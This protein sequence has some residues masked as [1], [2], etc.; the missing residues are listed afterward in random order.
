MVI[1][2]IKPSIPMLREIQILSSFTDPELTQLSALGTTRVYEPHSSI[3]IEGESSWGV[4]LI[5]RGL[6]NISKTNKLS[7]NSYDLGRL[8]EGSFFGEMSLVDENP[9]SATVRALSESHLFYISKD[10]FNQLLA[11]A[12]GLK[13]RFFESCVKQ[14][15]SRLRTLG[16]DY[17]VSQYQ[18]WKTA[19]KGDDREAA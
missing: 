15:V 18:L 10:A 4:Y 3:V 13:L 12:P 16:D 2:D 17:V 11:Q 9:R 5:L 7:G 1:V 19:L 6:V 8:R 14:L